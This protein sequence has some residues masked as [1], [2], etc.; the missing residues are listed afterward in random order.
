MTAETDTSAVSQ[1]SG[2]PTA[3]SQ[4]YTGY[5]SLWLFKSDDVNNLSYSRYNNVNDFSNTWG[6]DVFYNDDL[7]TRGFANDLKD[8]N[9]LYLYTGD[10]QF[11]S[12]FTLGDETFYS[13]PFTN[14]IYT[15]VLS[16]TT[17]IDAVQYCAISGDTGV[18]FKCFDLSGNSVPS[19][20]GV[21]FDANIYVAS[22]YDSTHTVTIGFDE[23]ETLLVL[24]DSYQ[25]NITNVT[26]TGYTSPNPINNITFS[27]G[28][29]TSC[30][31]PSP[32]PTKTPTQTPTPTETPTQ[33]PTNTQT[34]TT[35]PTPTPTNTQTQTATA[36]ATAT[37]TPTNTQT[38]T[39]TATATAT[40]TPTPT[41]TQTQTATATATATS[42]TTAT[43]SVTPT[44]T[45]TPTQLCCYQYEITNY[46]TTNQVVYYTD[47]EGNS[48]QITAAGNG[49]QTYIS[50]ALEGTLSTFATIC[51]NSSTDCITWTPASYPCGGCVSPTP[52][53]TATATSTATPT[54]TATAT[55]TSTATATATATATPT[56]TPTPTETPV[57]PTAFYIKGSG[58][59]NLEIRFF[60][61]TDGPLNDGDVIYINSGPNQGCYTLSTFMPGTGD[62]GDITGIWQII[63]DCFDPLCSV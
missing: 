35:T 25:G 31:K 49:A 56:P 34:S 58:C 29:F 38:Q 59:T 16:S 14:E 52:T 36:T 32:T 61:Y 30:V 18:L 7:V 11:A 23:T 57:I 39:A 24:A 51:D 21:T 42:T 4:S 5:T 26:I 17:I 62:N 2:L 27:A 47:C 37:P 12:G 33:T 46:Y 10:S 50:C 15:Y 20:Y 43:P 55:A 44:N 9:T 48:T 22:V 41:N 28:T 54:A 60:S 8:F 40:A 1:L 13:E 45:P 6:T 3:L 19:I 63:D 53:Q